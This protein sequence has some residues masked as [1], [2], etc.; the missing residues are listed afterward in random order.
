MLM[1]LLRALAVPL[2]Y[3]GMALVAQAL[4]VG[5]P[6]AEVSAFIIRPSAFHFYDVVDTLRC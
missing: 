6:E 3:L 2:V 5:P 4:K 1:V